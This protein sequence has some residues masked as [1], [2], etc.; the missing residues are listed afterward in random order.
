MLNALLNFQ[1]YT[2]LEYVLYACSGTCWLI[3]YLSVLF[4]ARTRGFVGVPA[5]AMW[6]YMSWEILWGFVYTPN[7]GTLFAWALKAYLPL[8]A[9][10]CW[11]TLRHGHKQY[12]SG[13]SQHFMKA[14]FVFTLVAW[15][16]FLYFFIPLHDDA[17]GVTSAQLLA[18]MMSVCFVSLLLRLYEREGAQGLRQLSYPLAWLKLVAN[19]FT[20]LFALSA[21]PE[22]KWLHVIGLVIFCL[23]A[24]YCHAFTRL[25]STA[26]AARQAAGPRRHRR[27]AAPQSPAK[28]TPAAFASSTRRSTFRR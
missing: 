27:S 8:S 9:Y 17:A 15:L 1:A 10:I 4:Q 13:P 26:E 28:H 12:Q 5:I 22:R 21:F 24:F 6:A 3:L 20:S 2:P 18:L 16:A 25:R 14:G 23:D 19:I 7:L 11:L